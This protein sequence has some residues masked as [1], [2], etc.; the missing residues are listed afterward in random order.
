MLDLYGSKESE[1]VPENF[2]SQESL[3]AV[4]IVSGDP[5]ST[6]EA[7]AHMLQFIIAT[8]LEMSADMLD[9]NDPMSFEKIRK[10][11]L[12]PNPERARDIAIWRALKRRGD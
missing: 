12:T 1:T 10:K 11:G 2:S 9:R 4:G 8:R 7:L 6:P 5:P 3:R